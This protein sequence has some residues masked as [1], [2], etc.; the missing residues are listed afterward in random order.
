MFL[1]HLSF[2]IV[3]HYTEYTKI[4]R[5]WL[6]VHTHAHTQYT[7]NTRNQVLPTLMDN[8]LL[9]MH[10][11]LYLVIIIFASFLLVQVYEC[12]ILKENLRS[13]LVR[14]KIGIQWTIHRSSYGIGWALNWMSK[15]NSASIISV[16]LQVL[17]FFNK[18]TNF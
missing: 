12:M 15:Q 5:E 2:I 14:K 3:V 6:L 10:Y 4:I 13:E 8:Q 11:F 18:K 1:L 17:R 9:E 7:H 16:K